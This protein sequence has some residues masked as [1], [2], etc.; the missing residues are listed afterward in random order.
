MKRTSIY[1][2]VVICTALLWSAPV[3][4][5]A[6]SGDPIFARVE[7]PDRAVYAGDSIKIVF[8]VFDLKG[9]ESVNNEDQ[10]AQPE[11]TAMIEKGSSKIT[12]VAEKENG[13]YVAFFQLPQAGKWQLFA[14]V[15]RPVSKQHG[16]NDDANFEPHDED[17]ASYYETTI[18][19]RYG[20]E[21]IVP[22]W[23]WVAGPI[24]LVG[25]FIIRKV[26]KRNK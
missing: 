20:I 5:H 14:H 23:A 17:D 26:N 4:G 18:K 11:V 12:V 8:H 13:Q 24:L 6:G 9:L 19:V 3:L 22:L 7:L 1:F 25:L 21:K 15:E 16:D 2:I 10:L